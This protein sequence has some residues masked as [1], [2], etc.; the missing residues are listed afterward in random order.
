MGNAVVTNPKRSLHRFI[1]MPRAIWS[2]TQAGDESPRED[3]T[4]STT[5]PR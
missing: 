1:H 5:R 4:L 2:G 3:E